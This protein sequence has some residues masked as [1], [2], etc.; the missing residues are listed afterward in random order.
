MTQVSNDA[1]DIKV[2]NEGKLASEKIICKYVDWL[3][4][5]Y[6]PDPPEDGLWVKPST[7]PCQ[8]YHKDF[9]DSDSDYVDLLNMVQR[10]TRCSTSYCLKKRHNDTQ[11]K[12]RF[13][14]PIES[15]NKTSLKFE[16][17]N[18]KDNTYKYK[19]QVVT[20]RNDTRLNNHQRLQLQGWRANCDIQVVID[21]HACVEYLA[22]YAAKSESKSH[23]LRQLVL[24]YITLKQT[25]VLPQ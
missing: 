9:D 22:K 20:K 25:P 2:V 19:V 11:P 3:L 5:T 24:L 10:H 8:K 12:C 17:I 23:L 7:H 6:N 21:Y 15:C 13:N 18:S 16:Q 1:I 4:S 14:F